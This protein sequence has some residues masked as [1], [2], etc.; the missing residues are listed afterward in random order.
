MTRHIRIINTLDHEVEIIIPTVT[1]L[2]VEKTSREPPRTLSVPTEPHES[3]SL[4][5]KHSSANLKTKENPVVKPPVNPSD[6]SYPSN[7]INDLYTNRFADKLRES[8]YLS[9]YEDSSSK[10]RPVDASLCVIAIMQP[11]DTSCKLHLASRI[12]VESTPISTQRNSNP[13]D[14]IT[15]TTITPA[16]A[17]TITQLVHSKRGFFATPISDDAALALVLPPFRGDPDGHSSSSNSSFTPTPIASLANAIPRVVEPKEAQI[18]TVETYPTSE[19]KPTM[20]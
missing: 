7:L 5:Q 2:E 9:K 3:A 11:R 14:T 15:A 4:S 10:T 13:N 17:T 19:L 1:L 12:F 8:P 18:T 20:F 6:N 16:I